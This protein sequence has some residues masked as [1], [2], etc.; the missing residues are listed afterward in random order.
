MSRTIVTGRTF[1]LNPTIRGTEG[2]SIPKGT[3][4]QRPASPAEGI[5]RYNSTTGRFEGYSKNPNDS[6]NY[7]WRNIGIQKLRDN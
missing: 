6:A 2:I 7:M 4:D 1:N 5:I 3:T